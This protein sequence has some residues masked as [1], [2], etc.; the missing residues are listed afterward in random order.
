MEQADLQQTL[1]LQS[2]KLMN[3]Q[4]LDGKNHHHHR[5]LYTRSPIPS[6]TQSANLFNQTLAL[7]SMCSSPGFQEGNSLLLTTVLSDLAPFTVYLGY[8]FF[9]QRMALVAPQ[10]FR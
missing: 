4:L 9:S 7:P 10:H 8:M 1:E 2:Q 3:L 5:A 6:P